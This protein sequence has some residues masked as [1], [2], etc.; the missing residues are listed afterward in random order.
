MLSHFITIADASWLLQPIYSL[1]LTI[2][3]IIYSLVSYAYKIFMLMTQLNY[4]VLYTILAPL[5]DRVKAVIMVFILFKVGV[6]FLQYLV[7]PDKFDEKTKGGPALLINILVVAGLLGISN[8]V[9]SL[10]ND[11]SMLVLG[12]F[13]G[14]ASFQVIN[15]VSGDKTVEVG[16]LS[17]FIYGNNSQINSADNFGKYLATSTMNI[18]LHDKKE[19]IVKEATSIYNSIIENKDNSKN[20]DFDMM[21]IVDLNDDIGRTV[22]YRYPLLSTVMGLY[23]IYSIVKIAIEVGV[24]MFKLIVLQIVAPIAIISIVSDGVN[25]DTFKKFIKTYT[26]TFTSVFIRV[27]SMFLIT[28]F[29]GEFFQRLTGTSVN[30][31]LFGS[32]ANLAALSDLTKGILLVV[33]VVAGY[34]FVNMLPKF[35][36]EIFGIDFGDSDKGGFGKF[37]KGLGKT[38]STAIGGA[39]GLASGA[40]SG[41]ASGAGFLGT[42]YNALSGAAHGAYGGYK[43]NKIADTLKGNRDRA[44]RIDKAG[45]LMA[46]GQENIERGLGIQGIQEQRVGG[47]DRRDK[48]A[49]NMMNARTAALAKQE[50]GTTGRK[51]GANKDAFVAQE[52]RYNSSYVNALANYESAKKGDRIKSAQERVNSLTAASTDEERTNAN[53][54]LAAAQQEIVVAQNAVDAAY[55]EAKDTAEAVYDTELFANETVNEDKTVI[56]AERTYDR[57]RRTRDKSATDLRANPSAAASH[58]K[59]QREEYQ[60][61]KENVEQGRVVQ[62]ARRVGGSNK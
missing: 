28:G 37:M 1:L 6:A 41:G 61:R 44:E 34:T 22:Q 47:H 16:L 49:E 24:R 23:L 33:L 48:I 51:F 18:F 31:N 62:R 38:A 43:G 20:D 26:G 52:A 57:G 39:V 3:G 55:K 12:N 45:G 19:S 59:R 40:I 35:L 8:F 32:N 5:I 25:G 4:N 14:N 9:F 21:K 53:A 58:I 60:G 13:D 15:V 42:A 29:I 27:A 7:E 30:E 10:F 50:Y 17:R 11:L 56:A 54:A 36:S 2:D 46:Y